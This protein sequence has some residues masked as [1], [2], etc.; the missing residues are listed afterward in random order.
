MSNPNPAVAAFLERLQSRHPTLERIE[1]Q[2]LGTV[3]MRKPTGEDHAK[4]GKIKMELS[5]EKLAQL[6]QTVFAAVMGSVMLLQED[7]TPIFENAQEGF[8]A[9]AK[10]DG[11]DL[12]DLYKQIMRITGNSPTAME[13]AEKKSSSSQTSEPGTN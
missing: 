5:K 11:D 10:I 12:H 7:G 13:D 9:L 4:I 3:Y 8:E 2:N 1:L 6:P